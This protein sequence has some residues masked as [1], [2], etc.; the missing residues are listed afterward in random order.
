MFLGSCNSNNKKEVVSQ[1][2][3]LVMYVPSEM[4]LLMREMFLFQEDSKNQIE[5]GKLPL[6]FPEEFRKI[7]TAELSDQ[8]ENDASFKGF[9]YLYLQNVDNLGKSTKANAKQNFNA[10]IQT[11]IACHQTTCHGP[12]T[13]IKKLIIN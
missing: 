11:C 4:T 10:V 7:H 6:D 8:F 3:E 13:R 12:I 5:K 1:K 9:T 2:E